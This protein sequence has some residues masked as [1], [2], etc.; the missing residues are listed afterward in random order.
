MLEG[1]LSHVSP[2]AWP[3]A[4]SGCD[5]VENVL[6]PLIRDIHC[7]R[8]KSVSSDIMPD[9]DL[10]ELFKSKLS[11]DCTTPRTSERRSTPKDLVF[12]TGYELYYSLMTNPLRDVLVVI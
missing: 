11:L 10:P 6:S 4:K 1:Y 12:L 9:N 3:G 2:F 8:N 7:D 5:S